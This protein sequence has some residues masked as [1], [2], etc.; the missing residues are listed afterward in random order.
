MS[1]RWR[2]AVAVMLAV[3]TAAWA[4]YDRRPTAGRDVVPQSN[5]PVGPPGQAPGELIVDIVDGA[6][7]EQIAQLEQR[8]G[9]DL[10]P[11][12]VHSAEAQ[13][14]RATVAEERMA[15]L[16]NRL[17]QD[18]LVEV[19]ERD[20]RYGIQGWLAYQPNDP[21]YR[22][23]WHLDQISMPEAWR[24]GRGHRAVVAVIDTGVAYTDRG[25][26]F[27]QV[28]DLAGTG[29]VPGYDFVDN[30]EYPLDEHGHGTHVA[31]TIAQT[32]G[33][34]VGVAGVAFE[35]A[36]MP[37][38]VLNRRGFGSYGDIADAIRFAADNG[39]DVINMSLG[40][41]LP[42]LAIWNAVRY[43]RAKGVVVVAAA[44]NTG[45][46]GVQFPGALAQVIGVSAT[47][48][49]EQLTFYSSW[50]PQIDVAAPGGDVRVDQNGDG[51]ADGVLQN[52]IVLGDPSESDYL[53]FNGT[54]M[55]SPHVA[56]VAA[57]LVAEGV[58]NPEAVET[59]LERT[60]RSEG[61]N[62]E[63]FGA[64]IIDAAAAL[65]YTQLRLGAIRLALALAWMALIISWLRRKDQLDQLSLLGLGVG[66][67]V[68]SSGLFFLP[69]LAGPAL[70]EAVMLMLSRPFMAW[71]LALLGPA[72]HAH[73]LFHSALIP[74]ALVLLGLGLKPL[75]GLIAGL[76]FGGGVYLAVC[77]L[78]ATVDVTYLPW[79]FLD[80]IW[81]WANA[82]FCLLLGTIVLRRGA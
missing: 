75:R 5:L 33:N 23:Q 7:P 45:R 20:G 72:G 2:Q 1:K 39:A 67:I 19:A 29:F 57:L 53:L 8:Y 14:Q 40:G 49:D 79:A 28:P 30:D 69:V 58:T 47:R 62:V 26:G 43:A 42:S 11:N 78:W 55:A 82:L 54:S 66:T 59:I 71:D 41:P 48:Y 76:S 46:R 3:G 73:P 77:A 60:A 15:T 64:G 38:R 35:A 13:L 51:M 74:L 80:Q 9:L 17:R 50:G 52:T 63:Q 81:L 32:T 12:S 16:I 36:I 68:G 61:R 21:L 65:Q 24:L 27:R 10:E 4:A 56:G 31:G 6:S 22:H 70:P 37:L 44:G 18:P 34:E 25:E